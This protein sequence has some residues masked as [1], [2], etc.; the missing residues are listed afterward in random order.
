MGEGAR[1]F[2][3]TTNLGVSSTEKKITTNS[4]SNK[5]NSNNINV[6]SIETPES[7][8]STKN[9][10]WKS[11][12]IGVVINQFK[13]V[14]TINIR[15]INPTFSWQTRFYD[16]VIRDEKESQNIRNYIYY[17]TTKW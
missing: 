7:G 5:N 8:V 11:G 3:E 14:C 13:R 10:K 17:N 4:D 6:D 15:K 12:T 1:N 2:V 16:R 9:K